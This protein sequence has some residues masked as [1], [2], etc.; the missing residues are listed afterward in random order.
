MATKPRSFLFFVRICGPCQCPFPHGRP[1]NQIH[2][3]SKNTSLLLW[4][5]WGLCCR[6][7]E[8]NL[9]VSNNPRIIIRI[10]MLPEGGDSMHPFRGLLLGYGVAGQPKAIPTDPPGLSWVQKRWTAVVGGWDTLGTKAEQAV[11][12]L[13]LLCPLLPDPPCAKV[14][15]HTHTGGGWT[16]TESYFA[17]SDDCNW[18]SWTE[19]PLPPAFALS[20]LPF[21]PSSSFAPTPM[22]HCLR[23]EP[24]C[25][26][27]SPHTRHSQAC[28]SN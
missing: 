20:T 9:N 11:Q 26:R 15:T 27:S 23:A 17:A 5:A 4:H 13:S 10:N 16:R 28:G 21:L 14:W 6:K 12:K 3:H 8:L 22:M 7:N 19:K 25:C 24:V 18:T 2:G 1:S